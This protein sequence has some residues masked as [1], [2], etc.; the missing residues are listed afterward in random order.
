[1]PRTGLFWVIPGTGGADQ[2]LALPHGACDVIE[3][4]EVEADAAG[5][6]GQIGNHIAVDVI[7]HDA[8][9]EQHFKCRVLLDEVL[10][11]GLAFGHR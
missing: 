3:I 7:H 9:V 4:Q 8:R 2:G 10:S 5:W 11:R 6:N 1:M